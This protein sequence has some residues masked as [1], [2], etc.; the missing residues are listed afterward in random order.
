MHFPSPP[1]A[2]KVAA[3]KKHLSARRRSVLLLKIGFIGTVVLLALNNGLLVDLDAKLTSSLMTSA[4]A[5][6]PFI[7]LGLLAQAQRH[8]MLIRTSEVR[9]P[10]A[11]QAMTLAHGLNLVLPA[12][13][14]EL[15]K[16]TYLR[17]QADVPF[18]SGLSAVVLERLV[19]MLIVAVL[20]LLAAIQFFER[21][22]FISV[23]ALGL[24]IGAAFMLLV[25]FPKPVMGLIHRMPSQRLSGTLVRT[26]S[27]FIA[28]AEKKAF[29]K[30]VW[31]GLLIWSLS[32]LNIFIFLS[33]AGSIPVG[34]SGALLVFVMTTL[35]GA[36]PALP[37]GLG[38]YE[39]AAVIALRSL[40][41]SFD[42]AMALALVMHAAQ[43][44][45]PFLVAM[46]LMLQK[47]LGILSLISDIRRGV[48]AGEN[49][50]DRKASEQD[51]GK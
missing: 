40:G 39:A 21:G 13:L 33:L 31:L 18:S 45:L 44:A 27:H 26:Y 20:G 36:I 10:V 12:R 50:L 3:P 38:T 1:R 2:Y 28:T 5:M 4:A 46:L 48:T 41:Y 37:G 29:W 25:R 35:G 22:N 51:H 11:F 19:D 42:E 7:V 8:R 30:A 6:Q 16:V 24:L 43:L 17:D 49:Q 23:P 32:Y 34:L 9:L 47:R 15:I 14:S